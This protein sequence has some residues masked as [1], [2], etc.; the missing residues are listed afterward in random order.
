VLR[1]AR[2]APD[3]NHSNWQ[4]VLGSRAPVGPRFVA[5][6]KV[7]DAFP[8][9]CVSMP[10]QT[11]RRGATSV[12]WIDAP[13]RPDEAPESPVTRR[14]LEACALSSTET[15]SSLK[16]RYFGGYRLS[17]V[18]RWSPRSDPRTLLSKILAAGALPGPIAIRSYPRRAVRLVCANNSPDGRLSGCQSMIAYCL[19]QARSESGQVK[20][21]SGPKSRSMGVE[22]QKPPLAGR[23]APTGNRAANSL[24]ERQGARTLKWRAAAVRATESGPGRSPGQR[25]RGPL[26]PCRLG[27][28][29]RYQ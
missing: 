18:S 14:I 19:G 11:V 27:R 10:T 6:F 15:S 12:G 29:E 23:T 3:M 22:P 9:C 4:S 1:L 5:L 17:Y 7:Y 26:P 25:T 21:V 20:F 16:G 2:P 24:S 13:R 28:S 8:R